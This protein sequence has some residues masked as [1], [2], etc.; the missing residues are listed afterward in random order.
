MSARQQNQQ[1]LSRALG[2]GGKGRP[3]PLAKQHTEVLPGQLTGQPLTG[4]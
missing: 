4:M 3:S 1:L 2:N